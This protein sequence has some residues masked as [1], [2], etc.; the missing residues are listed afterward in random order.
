MTV[1]DARPVFS[2]STSSVRAW[3]P[4]APVR[5]T[6][7]AHKAPEPP[8]DEV[9]WR[10]EVVRRR[11]REERRRSNQDLVALLDKWMAEDD[12]EQAERERAELQELSRECP[13][14]FREHFDFGDEG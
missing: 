7:P 2:E 1:L 13:V 3:G 4:T 8:E 9:D 10:P 6:G 5:P 11:L 12:P 14:R